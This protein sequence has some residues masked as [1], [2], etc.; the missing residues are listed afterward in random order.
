MLRCNVIHSNNLR[1]PI[2]N[3]ACTEK[4]RVTLLQPTCLSSCMVPRQLYTSSKISSFCSGHLLIQELVV[5]LQDSHFIY[6]FTCMFSIA[7][8]QLIGRNQ[9]TLIGKYTDQSVIDN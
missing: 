7:L 3:K 9:Y 6:I 5:T 8:Q 4:T 2:E 1:A